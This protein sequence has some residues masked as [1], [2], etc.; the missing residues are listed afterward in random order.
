MSQYKSS[1]IF[2]AMLT[3]VALAQRVGDFIDEVMAWK[4]HMYRFGMHVVGT[5]AAMLQ[6]AL[7]IALA[8]LSYALLSRIKL[9]PH[10]HRVTRANLAYIS[11]RKPY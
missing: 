8:L 3:L 2:L 11:Q 5:N 7:I 6:M 9:Q 4:F 1:F 10:S